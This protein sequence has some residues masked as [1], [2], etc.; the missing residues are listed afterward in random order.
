MHARSSFSDILKAVACAAVFVQERSH[1][2]QVGAEGSNNEMQLGLHAH[3][4]EDE[5]VGLV[6]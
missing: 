3:P 5:L 2:K 4:G 6:G 1:K